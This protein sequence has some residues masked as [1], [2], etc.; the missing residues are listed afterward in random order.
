MD[1]TP[2]EQITV[3]VQNDSG[4]WQGFKQNTPEDARTFPGNHKMIYDNNSNAKV[5]TWSFD[6]FTHISFDFSTIF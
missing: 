3:T 2:D 5:Q 6:F 4:W 1:L